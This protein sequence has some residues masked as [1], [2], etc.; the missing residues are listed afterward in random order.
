MGRVWCSCA[1]KCELANNEGAGLAGRQGRQAHTSSMAQQLLPSPWGSACSC[2]RT[3]SRNAAKYGC[4]PGLTLKVT[5]V[6]EGPVQAV[7][8]DMTI[9]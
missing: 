8:V 4:Q 1:A 7:T 2:L 9:I 6:Q 3:S 5:V